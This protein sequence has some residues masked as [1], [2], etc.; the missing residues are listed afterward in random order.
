MFYCISPAS[1]CDFLNSVPKYQ[2]LG[3]DLSC[4]LLL[5]GHSVVSDSFANPSPTRSSP[6]LVITEY[7]IHIPVP[8]AKQVLNIYLL[9][10]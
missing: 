7:L 8:N 4:P 1:L 5:F 9:N 6:V 10:D 2:V 3:W